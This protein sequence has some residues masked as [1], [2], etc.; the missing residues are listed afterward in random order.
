M[1]MPERIQRRRTK[2]WRMPKGA[3]YVGRPTKWANPWKIGSTGSTVKPGGVI[4][5]QPHPPLTREQAVESFRNAAE[6]AYRD[7]ETLAQLRADLGG[8]DLACWCP[9]A[10]EQG[11][12]VPCHADVLLEIANQE[13]I[14]R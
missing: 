3:V 12:H 1:G 7:A 11:N 10:D 2:G 4:D 5:R 8:K 14:E 9:L 13:V 6:S